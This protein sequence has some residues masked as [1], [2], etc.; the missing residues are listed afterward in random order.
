VNTLERLEELR[1]RTPDIAGGVVGAVIDN[2]AQFALVA[3]GS[4]VVTRAL[5]RL[6]RP[7]GPASALMTATASYALCWWLLAEARRRGLIV[8]RVRHPVTGELVT[9][10]ELGAGPCPCGECGSADPPG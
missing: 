8:F 4:Y 6:V 1:R 9:L 10:A 7:T 2:P 5:G 3:S